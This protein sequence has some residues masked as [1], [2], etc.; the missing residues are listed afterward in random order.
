MSIEYL[1]GGSG[2]SPT[3]VFFHGL[4]GV[5]RKATFVSMLAKRYRVL[6]PA[7]PGFD[8]STGPALAAREAAKV[9]AGFIS[10]HCSEPVHLVGESA[11][12]GPACWLAI[13]HPALVASL[14]LVAPAALAER[15]GGGPPTP[16]Q[17]FGSHPFWTSAPDEE[18]VARRR[19][20]AQT[21]SAFT[22]SPEL[23]S[24]LGEIRARTLILWGTADQVVSPEQGR[25]YEKG[26][27]GA[28]LMYVY[29]GAHSLPIAAADHFAKLVSEFIE[30]G[31]AFLVNQPQTI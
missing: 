27:P 10:E 2:H 4:G 16:E 17:L 1:E 13:D 12:G 7:R 19:R 5:E 11:G 18:D 23:A 14:T 9:M 30:K 26:I 31:E 6:A 15:H 25:I 22:A 20:N 21:N 3:V 29:G 8:G 24:A 28:L